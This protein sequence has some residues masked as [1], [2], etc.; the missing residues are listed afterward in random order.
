MRQAGARFLVTYIPNR[1]EIRRSDWQ[2][3]LLR[4]GLNEERWDLDRVRRELSAIGRRH[5]FPVLDLTDALRVE[6]GWVRWPYHQHDG[7]W[8]SLGHQ[9]A[10]R[11]LEAFLRKEAWL[12]GC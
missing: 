3:T 11:E 5:G 8:N 9:I 12:A 7:H 10:A 4:Y 6:V 1:M 2:L